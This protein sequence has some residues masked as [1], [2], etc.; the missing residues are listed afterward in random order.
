MHPTGE[1]ASNTERRQ[2]R[3]R[4]SPGSPDPGAV[5][6]L[7]RAIRTVLVNSAKITPIN[8]ARL[9]RPSVIASSVVLEA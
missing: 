4:K 3:V 6:F 2:S 1:G 9:T 5:G 7:T 8:E